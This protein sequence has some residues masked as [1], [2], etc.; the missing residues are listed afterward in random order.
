VKKLPKDEATRIHRLEAVTINGTKQWIYVRGGHRNN[1]ILLFLHGGP[2]FSHIYCI[3]KYFEE[4]ESHF[5]VVDWDQRGSGKSYSPSIPKKSYTIDQFVADVKSMAILLKTR[6]K[7]DKI[8]LVGH[9]WGSMIGLLSVHLHPQLFHCYI[10]LGQVVNIPEG[11]LRTYR[12]LLHQ[13]KA[14][15]NQYAYKIL[16]KI[17]QP[18][19]VSFYKSMMFRWYLHQYGG[20]P[21]K[22]S[23]QLWLDFLQE[24]LFAPEY[25]FMD[26]IKWL[27][28]ILYLGKRLEKEML[29]V[30]FMEQIK[31]V[32]V[33]LYFLIGRFDFITPSSLVEEY[34]HVIDSPCKQLIPF[35]HAA[36]HLHFEENYKFIQVC[37]EIGAKHSGRQ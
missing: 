30:H 2:G 12:F 34:F 18:P 5:I 27:K 16:M 9:S 10:G 1:P 37:L 14:Q 31:Q 35:E 25:S 13:S 4:L 7:K 26:G 24:M 32:Q 29:A 17:G 11:D 36:H 19:Y 28:G 23:I 15:N 21:M 8:F 33:P 3:K 22:K 6:Y 20:Y